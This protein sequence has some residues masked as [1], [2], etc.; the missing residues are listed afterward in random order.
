MV[1]GP[2]RLDVTSPDRAAAA[3]RFAT[4]VSAVMIAFQVAGRATRDA[5]YLSSFDVTSLPRM[6]GTAAAI[7]LACTVLAS[8]ALGRWGPARL[9]PA[10]FGASAVLLLLESAL[11]SVARQP[12]AILVFLHFNALGALLVSMFWS[13]VNERFDP[14][15][16]KRAIGRIGAAGTIGGVVGGLLAERAAAYFSIAAMLPLLALLHAACAVLASRVG[17]LPARADRPQSPERTSAHEVLGASRYVR[18]LGAIVIL[19]TVGEGLLDYVFKA[20]AQSTYG[21]GEALLRFFAVF[22]A[23]TNLLGAALQALAGRWSLERLGLARTVGAL[24]WTVAGGAVGAIVFPGLPSATLAKGGEAVVRNSLYRSG[25][26]L[27][28]TP[29]PPAEKR[30]VK[31]VLDVGAV[32]VGDLVAAGLVQLTL[33]VW[34]AHAPALMLALAAAAAAT[35]LL[36]TLEIHTGYVRTLERNL[37]NF[38]V[39]LDAEDIMDS[40]TRT[41]LL[42]TLAAM[43]ALTTAATERASVAREPAPE[44]VAPVDPVLGRLASLR[45]RDPVV[46]KEALRAGPLSPEHVAQTITLLAWDAVAREA[47]AALREAAPRHAGQLC[48]ALLDP[49]TDFA[50]RRRVASA[51]AGAATQRS[52]DGLLGALRDPRFEVRFRAAR[53]LATLQQRESALSLDREA[54]LAAV[55]R[56][57]EMDRR[58]WESQRLLDPADDD[59]L[60]LGAVVR[61]RA[62]RSLE[63]VF[64]L[65]ALVLP[66]QPLLIAFRGLQTDDPQL[67]GTALEYLEIALPERVRLKLWPFLDDGPSRGRPPR[68]SDDVLAALIESRASIAANLEKL[69][70]HPEAPGDG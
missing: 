9:V 53:S 32:R 62:S 8:R 19:A 41:T 58:V 4:A 36:V 70:R 24:P 49:D 40:T 61:E 21:H 54:V 20:G 30:A 27:L 14:R 63:H 12:A 55:L 42:H 45:S 56:E 6:V 68:P 3:I 7:T 31:A 35:G 64:T 18:A 5:L 65:L 52:V 25:Y 10:L 1:H 46:V 43:P 17:T 34:A 59:P 33:L 2:Y 66:H 13:L 28:F 60:A 26:E 47:I 69:R 11:L 51:L 29:L 44:A 23:S 22:Y 57:A 15:T 37:M 67:R 38:A 50:V 16:A 48:D 39:Q